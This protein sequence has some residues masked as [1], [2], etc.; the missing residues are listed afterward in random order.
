MTSVHPPPSR[1]RLPRRPGR[2]ARPS[3]T[4]CSRPRPAPSRSRPCGG[5]ARP[6]GSRS[7]GGSA[8]R[9]SA[10]SSTTWPSWGS[11][12]AT[13]PRTLQARPGS[14]HGYD[15]FDHGADQRRDRRRGGPR[16][17]WSACSAT[18]AWGRSSTS[19]RTTW[20]SPAPT[21]SG[22]TCWRPARRPPRRGSSTSTGTRSRRSSTGRVLLPILED[23]Y[24][25]VLEAGLLALERDGG[26]FFIR[27]H[28]FRLPL[29]PRSYALVLGQRAEELLRRFDPDDD[30]VREYLSIRDAARNLPPRSV[31]DPELVARE[32]PREGGHQAADPAALRR[33]PGIRAFLDENVAL[34]RGTPGDPRSFDRMHRLLRGAGLPPGL[35]AGRGRGDQLPPVL[36][37]QRAG[38]PAHRGPGG[39]RRDPRPDL[40][41]GRPGE[42]HRPADRPPRRPGRPAGL[43]P[44]AAGDACSSTPAA[45]ASR[46]R[47][48]A[49]TGTRSPSASGSVTGEALAAEPASRLARR[50]PIVA[51]KILSRGEDLPASTGRSTARS[52]TSTSTPSTACS[53]TRRP[54][55]R[56][57][58]IY[59]RVHGRPRAVRRGGLRGQ[60]ADHPRGAWPAS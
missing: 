26:A 24:G 37:H 58:A 4:P 40:P 29:A 23:Q 15:V 9:T 44:P 2:R 28:D 52:A 48:P 17:G 55:T 18:G 3:P 53:S 45:A 59:R 16:R 1:R 35:L 33:E 39:L 54:P 13:S 27:Y 10:G 43:L 11:A 32:A 20:G 36:R 34:F 30:H 57:E 56:S 8:W 31:A 7:T 21:P 42:R 12:T 6:I 49:P 41:L 5:R 51:E 60:A 38:R 46:P 14:T 25:K 47:T 22:S 50:F 19:S